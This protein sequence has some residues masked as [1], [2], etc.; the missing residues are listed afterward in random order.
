MGATH[1]AAI[2]GCG[3]LTLT[4][5]ERAFFRDA[6]P[7]GFI[8]FARNV[9][10]P[11]QLRRLTAELRD[12]VGRDAPVAIDQEGGRVQR[13]RAPH[14]R[15]WLPPLDQVARSAPG[16]MERGI[17]LRYRLIA[18]ELRAVGIDMNCAPTCDLAWPETH[19]FLKNRCFGSDVRTVVRAGRA[20]ADGML[21]GGVLPVLKHIPG[22]GRTLVDSHHE[23]PTAT[24]DRDDLFS[25]DFAPFRALSDLPVGMTAHIVVPAIDAQNP[26]TQSPA[27]I[28]VIRDEIGFCGLLMTD[29]LEMQ[30]LKGSMADRTRAALGAGCDLALY[31]KA[32][33]EDQVAVATAAGQ[34]TPAAMTRARFALSQR[35]EPAPIDATALMAELEALILPR[36]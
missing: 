34:M 13:L 5:W 26:S 7:F 25:S 18:D 15:E 32:I 20:A 23:L 10:T 11:D 28:R 22:H 36:D 16:K 1:G 3:G 21:A 33:P 31:C 12:C 19:P 35:V 17:W 6:D 4:D 29:D 24:A 30:A 14:W 8:L 2:L 27:M 9:D